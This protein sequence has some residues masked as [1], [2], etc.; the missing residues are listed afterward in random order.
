METKE[1]V[2]KFIIPH[3]T[4]YNKDGT[5]KVETDP[6]DPGNIGGGTKYGIDSR[7]HPGIDVADLTL[8]GAISIYLSEYA[9]SFSSKLSYPLNFAFF[10]T[11][12]NA[13]A[14]RAAK[15]IQEGARVEADGVLGKV[16][17]GTIAQWDPEKL[18]CRMLEARDDFYRRLGA[19]PPRDK[20]LQ[21]WLNRTMDLRQFL[22]LI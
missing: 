8:D 5:V 14:T 15:C 17:K 19:K 1:F 3:E 16:S 22:K 13:G 9:A 6:D 12:V 10:D 11:E 20:F 18:A 7:S 2:E 21:G 4:E